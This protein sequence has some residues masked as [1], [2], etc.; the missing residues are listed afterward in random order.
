MIIDVHAHLWAPPVLNQNGLNLL[1]SDG[2]YA[3]M[4]PKIDDDVFR[5][6]LSIQLKAM[7]QVGTD[8]QMVSPRPF[9][10]MHSRGARV[11][12]VWT[13]WTNNAI[14]QQIRLAPGRFM[15]MAGLPQVPGEPVERVFPEMERCIKESRYVLCVITAQYLAS[16]HTSEEAII[17]KTLDMA[18]QR[19]RLV[20]LVF[21]RVELPVWLHGLVGIDFTEDA[22][23]EPTERLLDL[24][25]AQRAAR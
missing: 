7:D 14:A 22:T 6:H 2:S 15:G 21:E 10:M 18:D 16:D 1:G 20:P 19:K 11:V 23:V 4:E 5:D 12:D 3:G 24:V 13:R 9:T 8:L 25:T 17:S